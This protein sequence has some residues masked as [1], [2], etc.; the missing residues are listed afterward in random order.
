MPSIRLAIA[1]AFVLTTSACAAA[2]ERPPVQAYDAAALTTMHY[3]AVLV[4]GD[5][6]LPVFD[7]AVDGIATRLRERGILASGALQRLSAAPAVIAQDSVRL[8]SLDHVLDAIRNM[9]PGAG[10]GCFVFAT[11]HGAAYRGLALAAT[12][13]ILT[14][15]T[16]DRALASGCGN[17]PTVVIVSGCFT[18]NFTQVP[19]ARPNRVIL[20]A[21]RPDRASFGCGAGRAYT[22]YDR[23][24]LDVLD[25][26]GAWNQAFGSVRRCVADEERKGRFQRSEPQAYFG[27]AVAGLQFPAAATPPEH[28]RD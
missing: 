26:G 2:P 27:P 24:L 7:N 5:G 20:A 23:C 4:A 25:R 9:Q 13:E 22:V 18:G 19:M 11:S 3:K 10:E 21:A 12:D 6:N 28:E 16:L 1:L 8:A 14:P 15:G 17:A